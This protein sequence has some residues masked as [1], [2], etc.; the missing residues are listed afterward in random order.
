MSDRE[1]SCDGMFCGTL[2]HQS[3]CSM[4][5]LFG[6]DCGKDQVSIPLSLLER[7]VGDDPCG[8]EEDYCFFCGQI[9]HFGESE[10]VSRGTYSVTVWH[11][12]DCPYVE[13]RKLIDGL[14]I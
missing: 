7:L 6:R 2:M 10:Q 1:P 9:G 11:F 12:P 8:G 13:A 3:G 14:I 4:V 5:S